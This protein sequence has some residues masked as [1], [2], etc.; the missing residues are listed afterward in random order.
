MREVVKTMRLTAAL[1]RP[2]NA[3]SVSGQERGDTLEH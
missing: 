2:S 1:A 3:E